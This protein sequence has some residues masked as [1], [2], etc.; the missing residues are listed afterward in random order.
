MLFACKDL[1]GPSSSE[2]SKE[3]ASS[4]FNPPWPY[5]FLSSLNPI[6]SRHTSHASLLP[7]IDIHTLPQTTCP[8][9]TSSPSAQARSCSTS[10][11]PSCPSFP[12]NNPWAA[13][14]PRPHCAAPLTRCCSLA[15]GRR[16]EG[17]ASQ[18]ARRNTQ[19]CP[20]SGLHQG[21]VPLGSRASRHRL[22]IITHLTKTQSLWVIISLGPLPGSSKNLL[23]DVNLAH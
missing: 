13:S 15:R 14:C 18:N 12:L 2:F 20:R 23:C 8:I 6:S 10:H 11:C 7:I 5:G 21:A 9:S 19:H 16:L 4:L 17:T 22:I 1:P 3:F